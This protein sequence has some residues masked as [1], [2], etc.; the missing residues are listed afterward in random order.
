VLHWHR[1]LTIAVSTLTL[2]APFAAA[3]SPPVLGSAKPFFPSGEGFG[4]VEP[5][6]VYLGG[7]PTGLFRHVVWH[8]WDK[9]TATGDGTGYY[10]PGNKPV[11]AAVSTPVILTATKLG[12][13]DGI[14]AYKK[15]AIVFVYKGHEYPGTTINACAGPR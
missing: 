7:D 2:A 6:T 12:R 3:S 4:K 8:G 1:S 10:P 14:A 5:K 9:P 11:A 13:C 15:L